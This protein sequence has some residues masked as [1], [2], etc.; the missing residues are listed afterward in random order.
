MDDEINV[1]MDLPSNLPV[2]MKVRELRAGH[3]VIDGK[4]ELMVQ[5]T[6]DQRGFVLVV[7]TSGKREFMRPDTE[8]SVRPLRA[9]Q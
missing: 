6:N 2:K 1:G 4:K 3:R 7:F 5:S 9:G 8:L